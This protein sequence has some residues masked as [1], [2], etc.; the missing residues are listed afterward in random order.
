[1]TDI[2]PRPSGVRNADL[3]G[4]TW[5]VRREVE[6]YLARNG[7]V[8]GAPGQFGELWTNRHN[9]VS[10]LAVPFEIKM[11]SREFQALVWRL[12]EDE[13]REASAVSEALEQ[14]FQDVQ[15]YRIADRFVSDESVLLDSAATVL[16]SARG[17]LRAA[18]TTARK[19]RAYIGSAFS[20]PADEIARRARLSHTRRGSFVL[21][22]VMPIDPPDTLSDHLF[23]AAEAPIETDERRVTRT[24]AAALAALDSI[25]IRPDREPGVA[26]V[27][28][29]V[30]S[31]VSKEL[32]A[33]VRAIATD[34]GVHAFETSFE[35]SAGV[36]APGGMP[37][38]ILI[39]DEAA[40]LLG[41]VERRLKTSKPNVDQS[42]SGQIIEIRH[43][44]GEPSGEIAIR[45][46]RDSRMAELRITTTAETIQEAA[47]WFKQGRAILARGMVV[48]TPGRP[49][50]MPSPASVFPIDELYLDGSN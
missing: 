10:Q 44:P 43:L 14:E 21:P 28:A 18:A 4:S 26:E 20:R 50:S 19:P 13:R 2:T 32:V 22:V 29:L 15:E 40:P 45:T 24:L 42:V 5:D 39:S 34:A 33:A 37:T 8:R 23:E 49:L 12:A 36:G 48:T 27:L 9:D 25:A 47:D 1:M 46:A 7:W 30:E 35:W 38:R 3:S 17:L 41:R 6:S 31:G 11:D 16:G